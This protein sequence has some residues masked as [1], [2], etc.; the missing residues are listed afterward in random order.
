MD[1]QTVV[2]AVTYADHTSEAT[3]ADGLER[4]FVRPKA[5]VVSTKLANQTIMAALADPL[6]HA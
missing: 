1:I 2:D 3:N 6:L 5:D 4:I